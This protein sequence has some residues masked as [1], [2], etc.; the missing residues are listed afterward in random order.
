MAVA[1][2]PIAS[3]GGILA[4]AYLFGST[5]T[6]YLVARQLKGIDIRACG[7]GSTGATNV[8]R[9]V[10]KGPA[11]AVLIIDALKGAIPVLLARWLPEIVPSLPGSWQDWLVVGSALAAIVGHSKS[12]WLGFSGGKSVATS[13]GVLLAITPLLGVGTLTTFGLSL[14]LTRIVSISSI[15]GAVAVSF[16]AVVLG[17]SLPYIL[18]CALAGGYV[19]W[20]HRANIGRLLAGTEPKIGQKLGNQS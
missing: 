3:A 8:L 7:S 10:G 19:I 16:I 20:R 14:A 12:M 17:L 4:I 1:I 13:L 5:P 15:L 6:G 9:T 11:L 18:F 2:G